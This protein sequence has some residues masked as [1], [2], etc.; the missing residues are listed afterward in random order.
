MEKL[1]TLAWNILY[2]RTLLFSPALDL[3]HPIR[4]QA[5]L[6]FQSPFFPVAFAKKHSQKNFLIL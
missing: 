5:R 3:I 6:R 1:W 2:R 4:P